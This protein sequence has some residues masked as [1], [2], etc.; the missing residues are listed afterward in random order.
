MPRSMSTLFQNI[1]MQNP[2][3]YSTPTDGSLELLYGARMNFTSSPE[4]KAQ[5]QTLML[6]AWRGFCYAALQGYANGLTARPNICIKSRGIGIHYDWYNAFFTQHNKPL[7]IFCMV[8]DLRQI[9]SSMEKIYRLNQEK[10][11]NIQDHINMAGTT[12]AKR[13]DSWIASPPIGLAL[14]RLE[15]VM[16]E[17][18]DKNIFFIRSEDLTSTPEDAMKKVY[19]YLEMPVYNHNFDEVEQYTVED[20]DVYGLTKS[21]HKI[22]KKVEPVKKDYLEVLGKESSD[23]INGRFAWYQ[24][25]FKYT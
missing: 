25:Y 18:K 8:R 5:D 20:D 11:Q 21:L 4:F 22:R 23:W 24:K 1:L 14:E 12:T 17:G 15:Q 19:D 3:I 7:R 2:E 13:I 9:F 6:L 10:H 16:R